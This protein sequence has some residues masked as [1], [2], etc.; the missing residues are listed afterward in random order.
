MNLI[1]KYINIKNCKILI[2]SDVHIKTKNPINRKDYI[3]E[4]F[5]YLQSIAKIAMQENYNIVIFL[6]DIYDNEFK[7]S[8]AN[9]LNLLLAGIIH[10]LKDNGICVFT[11]MGNHEKHTALKGCPFFNMINYSSTRILNDLKSIDFRI[12]EYPI[13]MFDTCDELIIN[14]K[15]CI[16]MHHF[17]DIDKSYTTKPNEFLYNIGVFHDAIL[18]TSAR[19][20]IMNISNVDLAQYTNVAYNDEMFANLQYAVC[21]DIH[22]RIGEMDVTTSTGVCKVDIPGSVMRTK[23]GIAESHEYVNL[24]LFTVTDE[25]VK[26]EYLHFKLWKYEDSFKEELIKEVK[27]KKTDMK[28][29]KSTIESVV[30]RKSFVED[31]ETF[32]K[33]IQDV[34]KEVITYGDYELKNKKSS[35]EFLQL[36][37]S[38]K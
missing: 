22:T 37:R 24:P 18:P 1:R 8:N 10:K 3:K 7:G 21:G 25:G 32:P 29:F 34:L 19:K 4:V 27:Q 14:N 23:S 16:H 2:V 30:V 12:P 15:L 35:I 38:L 28:T 5:D 13:P 26:K 11:L 31:L 17:S 6:G 36:G 20:H 33:Y 9:T